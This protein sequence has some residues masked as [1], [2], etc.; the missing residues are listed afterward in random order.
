MI[1]IIIPYHSNKKLLYHCIDSLIRTTPKD[2]RIYII[3]NNSNLSELDI[4]FSN[5]NIKIEKFN[6]ELYYPT[7]INYGVKLCKGKDI[8]LA[9]ADTFYLNGWLEN[10]L[11]THNSDKKIAIT[12]SNIIDIH[13]SRVRAFGIAFNGYN[14]CNPYRGQSFNNNQLIQNQE[15]QAV[16]SANCIINKKAFIE[17][18]GFNNLYNISYCDIDLCLRLRNNGYKVYGSANSVVY[19]KGN[20]SGTANPIRKSDCRSQFFSVMRNSM[21]IDMDKY[22]F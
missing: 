5:A 17:V 14:W 7:A 9:D 1:E 6:H 19:H 3:S 11:L 10:L 4:Y 16:C 20:A 2:T 21:V 8:I 22:I 18:G 13:T 12:G 15:F